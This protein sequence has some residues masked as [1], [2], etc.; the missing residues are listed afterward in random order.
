MPRL[1]PSH[2]GRG[3]DLSLSV[4]KIFGSST[5]TTREIKEDATL[6]RLYISQVKR[7]LEFPDPMFKPQGIMHQ[8]RQKKADNE[9]EH[10]TTTKL[11][12]LSFLYH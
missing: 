3:R 10:L 6:L 4:R 12:G 11:T 5:G 2:Q 7:E 1:L 8:Q 9:R